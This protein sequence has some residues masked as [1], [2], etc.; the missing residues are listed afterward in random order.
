MKCIDIVTLY[1][2]PAG[3]PKQGNAQNPFQGALLGRLIQPSAIDGFDRAVLRARGLR[4]TEPAEDGTA[5]VL[6]PS[7]EEIAAGAFISAADIKELETFTESELAAP[8]W[9]LMALSAD[10]SEGGVNISIDALDD[11]GFDLASI[12]ERTLT[13]SDERFMSMVVTDTATNVPY[14]AIVKASGRY[15]CELTHDM[16]VSPQ[17]SSLLAEVL[18]WA[19]QRSDPEPHP[20]LR[21]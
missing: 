19:E 21:M 9:R 17:V 5:E 7:H 4:L 11:S 18:R 13:A 15:V 12:A 8:F 20:A 1:A 14:A 2:P 3:A 10:R 16:D 6:P